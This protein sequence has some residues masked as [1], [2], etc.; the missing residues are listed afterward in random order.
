MFIDWGCKAYLSD[1]FYWYINSKYFKILGLEIKDDSK[2]GRWSIDLIRLI[3]YWFKTGELSSGW[4]D[5]VSVFIEVR[6]MSSIV[7]V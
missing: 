2:L 5:E 3:N 4:T 7:E 6:S 1:K